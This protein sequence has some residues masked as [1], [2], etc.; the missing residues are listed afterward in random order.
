M[1]LVYYY[2]I[3]SKYKKV[4]FMNYKIT[5]IYYLAINHPKCVVKMLVDSSYFFIV[6]SIIVGDI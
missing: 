3:Y 1:R 6:L 4:V 2:F 5:F